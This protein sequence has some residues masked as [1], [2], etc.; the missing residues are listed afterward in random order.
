M[1]TWANSFGKRSSQRQRR[2]R[3]SVLALSGLAAPLQAAGQPAQPLPFF[4]LRTKMTVDVDGAPNAYGPR[5]LPTL[6]FLRNAHSDGTF[7]TPI[8]GYLTRDD[9]RTPVIQGPHDPCPGYYVSTTDF[10]DDTIDDDANPRKYL[11][12]TRI[13]YV[14]LGRFA[15]RHHLHLGD[16]VVVH[17][18]RTH[19]TVYAIAGD[20]GNPSG[21]EGSLALLRALGY[22]FHDGKD[23]AVEQREI[24]IRYFPGS[25][26]THRF[27]HSQAEIDRAAESLHLDRRF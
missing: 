2:L 14:V 1:F 21:G 22:P 3:S 17:S 11:D 25:N 12:A 9:H 10:R 26:P 23:D 15:K 8:V 13:S 7:G 16:L 18:D 24:V 6:D 20:S 5:N 19:R 4:D 27:F